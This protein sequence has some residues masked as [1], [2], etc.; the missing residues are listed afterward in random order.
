[1]L[2]YLNFHILNDYLFRF[3]LFFM[4]PIGRS[5]KTYWRSSVD[6]ILY[7]SKSKRI[8]FPFCLMY[9]LYWFLFYFYKK[10]SLWCV[11]LLYKLFIEFICKR[12]LFFIINILL[13]FII[14]LCSCFFF[15]KICFF[16]Y[17]PERKIFCFFWFFEI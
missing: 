6:W 3:P 11:V 1:M 9:S 7:S 12:L 17:I 2:D 5:F 13:R 16:I 15:L 14:L 10:V 4:V 8:I